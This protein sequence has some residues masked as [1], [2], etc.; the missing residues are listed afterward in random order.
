MSRH[1]TVRLSSGAVRGRRLDGY[2]S[3]QGI[4]YAAPPVGERRWRAPAPVEP[5]TGVRD[6]TEPAG[7][8]PQPAQPF[9]AAS[10]DEDC[11]TLDVT[12]PDAAPPAQ[13]AGRPVIIWLH[14]GGGT[15]GGSAGFD[16]HRLAAAGGAVVVAPNARLGV[17]ACFGHPGLADGGT[18]GLQ[19]QQAALRWVRRE[20]ARFGGD[21]GR[22]ALVGSSYG[23]LMIAA[24]LVSPAS[25]GLF[26]RAILQSPFSVLGA[27]PAHTLIPGV[28]ALPPRWIPAAELE[29][30]GAATAAEHGW[31]APGD[32]PEAALARLRRV[33][34]AELLQATDAFIRPAYGGATLPESPGTALPAGRFH[35]MPVMLGTTLDEA[36]F[37]VGLFAEL[38]G[39]PVTA[40]GYPRLLAEAFGGAAAEIAR[41]YPLDRFPTPGLAWAQISTD[42]AWARPT[43]E[44]GRAL[45]EHT[46]TWLY[47]FADRDA[48]QPVPLPGFPAGACH[49]GELA[50]QFDLPGAP[51][52]PAAQRGLADRMNRYWAAFAAHGE[53]AG[54]GLPDWPGFETGHVQSL[55]PEHIGGTDYA[56][57]HRLDLWERMP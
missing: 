32:D 9:A 30:F 1:V 5:W 35:R 41:H 2:Q 51:P 55:A 21:P 48:P 8:A 28:P 15:N 23:A 43:W 10:L 36:R 38:A 37:F 29:R 3:F 46:G 45:A 14:G 49:A 6:A 34:V 4:P 54:A 18:F 33:P 39:R 26:H 24:H 22:V 53:P 44:L 16:P 7:P 47:E 42:R 27:T 50:Y 25:A 19:D 13:G 56:A 12:V 17:L 31:T 40:E 20:I 57:E 52:L 11:L